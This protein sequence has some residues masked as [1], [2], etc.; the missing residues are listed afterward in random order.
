MAFWMPHNTRSIEEQER[1]KLLHRKVEMIP[2]KRQE[3]K[4]MVT[5][6]FLCHR[7]LL[8]NPVV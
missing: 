2:Q 6:S 8:T 3:E 7:L 5:I 1:K 4:E